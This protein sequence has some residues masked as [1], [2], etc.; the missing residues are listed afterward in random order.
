MARVFVT[1]GT[2][3]LGAYVIKLLLG[4]GYEV[5]ALSREKNIKGCR[6]IKGSMSDFDYTQI[7][8]CRHAIH[9][10]GTIDMSLSPADI[11]RINVEGTKGIVEHCAQAGIPHFTFISSISVYG[12]RNNSDITEKTALS[13]DTPYAKSKFQGEMVVQGYA[14]DVCILRPSIIYGPGFDTG[15]RM[16]YERI[17]AGKMFLFGDGNN[18][19][20]LVHAAD[21]ANAIQLAV[22]ENATGIYNVNDE[23]E[24]TQKELLDYVAKLTSSPLKYKQIPRHSIRPLLALYNFSRSLSKKP[25]IPSEFVDMLA[26]ERIVK[27]GKIRKELGF[28]NSYP[29][30]IGIAEFVDYLSKRHS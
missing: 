28:R 8:G 21:V 27:T 2:G 5:V 16:A 25:P 26:T 1:G 14:G 7:K 15:F 13:P 9:M 10:A 6:T 23:D 11:Y 3:K 30:K 29:A 22:A 19:V 17:K 20:P 12:K 24:M 4:N 18:H